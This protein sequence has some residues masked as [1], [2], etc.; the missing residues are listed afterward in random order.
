[1]GDDVNLETVKTTKSAVEFVHLLVEFFD[2][3]L[4]I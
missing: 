4:S 1:M 2:L 3:N